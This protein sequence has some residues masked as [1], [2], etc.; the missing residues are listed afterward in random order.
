M[1]ICPPQHP[2]LDE[3]IAEAVCIVADT[4]RWT[5]QVVSSQRRAMDPNKLGKEV[6]VS[7]LV[8]SLLQSTHQLYKL[9]LSPNFVREASRQRTANAA[10]SPTNLSSPPQCIMHLEDRL[11]E[12]Y[13]KSKMLAEYLKGQTRVHVKELGMVLG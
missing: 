1:L 10:N 7:C 4:D 3:P 8:S 2:V 13:F 11:Q 9:N 5:V 12:I 6:L